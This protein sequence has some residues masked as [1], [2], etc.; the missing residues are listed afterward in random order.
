MSQRLDISSD[1]QERIWNTGQTVVGA[2]GRDRQETASHLSP[3]Q[4]TF[5]AVLVVVGAVSAVALAIAPAPGPL[6]A[7]AVAFLAGSGAVWIVLGPELAEKRRQSI[8]LEQEARSLR[9]RTEQLEDGAWELRESDERHRSVIDALGDV[10]FR[11]DDNGHITYA[12]EAFARCFGVEL[13][14][15]VGRPLMLPLEDAAANDPNSQARPGPADLRLDTVDGQRW[16]SRLDVRV[17]YGNSGDALVQTILRDV[18][19]RRLAE[20]ALLEARDQAQSANRAKSRFL[21]TVSH[22]IR[23][24]LNG[25]LGMTGLLRDTPLSAAQDSYADAIHTSGEALMT[26]IDEVLDFS[27]IE[28]GKLELAPSATNL[29]ALVEGVV[30]LLAPRAQAK[31]LEIGAFVAWDVPT[32]VQI[33]GAR[34]RQV[35]INLAGNG[36][37]FTDAGGVL[38]EVCVESG[39]LENCRLQISVH[40]TGIGIEA[41]KAG[42]LFQEF[43]Q[44]DHGPARRYGGTGLGLAISQRIVGLMKGL[45]EVQSEQGFGTSFSF[46]LDVAHS[47]D[48]VSG[49][50]SLQAD[51]AGRCI[52][53]IADDGI[54]ATLIARRL[55][56]IGMQIRA[57]DPAGAAIVDSGD[58]PADGLIIDHM[59]L[60]DPAAWLAE[61]RAKGN[62]APALVLITPAQRTRLPALRAAGFSSYLI[63][64]VRSRSLL[65]IAAA[66]I[67][68]EEIS[69]TPND[70]SAPAT[71]D[72]VVPQ[73]SL[74]LL[75][76]EDNEINLRLTLA[77]LEKFGHTA[78]VAQ[79]GQAAIDAIE[80]SW[81]RA[82]AVF[83]A[84]FT[85]LHMP[86]VDGLEVIRRIRASEAERG[87]PML[88]IF[89]LT[90]DVM[91]DS[92]QEAESAGASGFMT[93]PLDPDTL[94]GVLVSLGGSS[95]PAN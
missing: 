55:N 4:I 8:A 66:L 28:A 16:F 14:A 18:T 73:Q 34:L 52:D 31:G 70:W 1:S 91:P 48:E 56:G 94:G 77:L 22:E 21:A 30:E 89:A 19:P 63:K 24:P 5:T 33:D 23:T 10:I 9:A 39:G 90:A 95:L 67:N 74:R 17:R 49:T 87:L 75:V 86:R 50:Q 11:R 20:D 53:L 92:R 57:M 37:K 61:E 35:L 36:I 27:K 85:D 45:I 93:K 2:S 84:V 62:K 13:A 12:N 58:N 83:D 79:D 69:D 46:T 41:D 29:E 26:L 68:G 43:E 3:S 76:A 42:R 44:V 38:I 71:E 78:V 54:E 25:I 88:P 15:V 82:G 6:A 60:D 7:V 72:A 64:P 40:D 32:E 59:A 65:R 81:S 80:E 47:G 51:L